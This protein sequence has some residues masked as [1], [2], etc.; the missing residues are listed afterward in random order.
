MNIEN[1]IQDFIEL[2]N[3][4]K[5]LTEDQLFT[6]CLHA[7]NQNSWFDEDNVKYALQAIQN[8]LQKD[9]LTEWLQNYDFQKLSPKRVAVIMAGNIPMVGFHDFLSVLLAGHYLYAKTSSQDSYLLRYLAKMLIE[10]NP[11]WQDK[12][13]FSETIMKNFEAVIATGSNNSARYFEQ[14][15]GKYPHIIRKNRTSVAVLTGK[16][17]PDELASLGNDIFRYYG[18]GCRNVSKIFVPQDYDFIP[19]LDALSI[20]EKAMNNHKYQNNYDYNKSIYL[21]NRVPH[22]DTG[23]LLLHE[24]TQLISPISVLYYESYANTIELEQ[25]LNSLSDQLQCITTSME[26]AAKKDLGTAQ[27]PSLQDYADGVDTMRFLVGL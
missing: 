11:I 15:F 13:E 3:R 4:L 23:F 2:G 7:K 9:A 17:T 8:Y 19:F 24:N 10:I 26:I 16:E 18:L 27:V 12:I 22:L 21:V 5:N 1:R 20:W 6:I 14:Y 25:K